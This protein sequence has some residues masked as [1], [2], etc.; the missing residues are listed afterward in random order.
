MKKSLLLDMNERIQNLMFSHTP[1]EESWGVYI[2][3]SHYKFTPCALAVYT[4]ATH[5]TS[6]P[7]HV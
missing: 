6:S 5:Y 3:S 4:G 2:S 7:F 1:H